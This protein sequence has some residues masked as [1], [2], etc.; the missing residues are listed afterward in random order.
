MPAEPPEPKILAL[1]GFTGVGT[2]FAPFAKLCGGIWH[3]PNL[4]GHGPESL[5]D[6]TPKATLN[7]IDS[8]AATLR[9]QLSGLRSQ[10]SGLSLQRSTSNVQG[11]TFNTLLGYSLGARAALLHA[12]ECPEQWDALILIS[13]NPG[14]EDP[15]ARTERRSVD[16]KLARRIESEGIEAFIEFWQS[17]P[18][19][20]SQ[21]NIRT[22]WREAMQANR[23][24]HT[25]S[26]LAASL[27]QFGQ[28]NCPNLWPV[29]Q[30]LTMPV[31]LL[32]G[33]EDVKYTRIARAM[34]ERLPQAMTHHIDGA[35]HMP[36]LEAP[37]DSAALIS[38]FLT[39]LVRQY[40]R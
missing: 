25:A 40:P 39:K 32:T 22:A 35:G 15:A 33:S 13:P 9:S 36:H 27:R 2:D 30:R 17:T 19:I 34:H 3:C 11:S 23:R 18:M 10:A 5:L 14:I 4:P 37:K 12:C 31:L 7:Y 38:A 26:G 16:E 28:G 21:Q 20:R 1:H 29:L 24:E 8:Q 6:C